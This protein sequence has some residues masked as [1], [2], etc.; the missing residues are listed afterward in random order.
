MTVARRSSWAV[1]KH[2]QTGSER[3]RL[4]SSREGI[5]YRRNRDADR[6]TGTQTEQ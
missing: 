2:I 4:D 6:G 1:K 5:R 3:G